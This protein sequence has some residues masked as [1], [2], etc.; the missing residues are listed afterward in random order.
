MERLST[1]NAAQNFS[2]VRKL[3]DK[4]GVVLL[5]TH[6]YLRYVVMD[7]DTFIQMRDLVEAYW[8]TNKD[9]LDETAL[10]KLNDLLNKIID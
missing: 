6:T 7:K 3:V 5:S 4:D 10:A 2:L 1:S 9:Y 8:L